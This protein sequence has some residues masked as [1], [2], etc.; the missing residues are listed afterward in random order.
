MKQDVRREG[1]GVGDRPEMATEKRERQ[2]TVSEAAGSLA[3][4][5]EL[6]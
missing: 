3:G 4:V 5:A 2:G 1:V 6:N